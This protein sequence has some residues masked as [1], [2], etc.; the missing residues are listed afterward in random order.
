MSKSHDITSKKQTIEILLVT[1]GLGLALLIYDYV[2]TQV[3]FDGKIE[4][5]AAGTGNKNEKL[6]L[7]FLDEEQELNVEISDKALSEDEI[8]SQF[9]TAIKEIDETYLGANVNANQINSD[10]NLK[11]SYCDGLILAYWKFDKYGLIQSSGALNEE[12]IP[13]SGEVVTL[14]CELSYEEQMRLYSFSVVVFPSDLG[15]IVNTVKQKD[16]STREKDVLVLP[17]EVGTM[18][19]SWRRSMNFRGLQLMLLGLITVAGIK[20]GKTR[21]EKK[22]KEE[23]ILEKEKDYP[24]IVS[25]LSILMSAGMSFRKALERIVTKYL[26][27]KQTGEIRPGYEDILYTYRKMRDGMGE[28]A[29]IEDLGLH[30]DS[31]EYR[32]LSMLLSQN[33]K[34]GSSE[35][36]NTLEKEEK[37]AFELRKQRAIRAGEEAST[38]L[39]IPMAGMLFIIILILVVPALMQMNI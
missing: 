28:L 15:N 21:D 2:D 31:K 39:L 3:N 6:R 17:K 20:I 22:L 18:E 10:L 19:L 7:M 35:L 8:E 25:E 5:S 27:K 38:K 36:I 11:S 23:L 34:K 37:Y 9:D 33:L 13:P 32:K 30:S 24:L 1:V 4:R 26:Q 14:T 16:K 12:N 29:A